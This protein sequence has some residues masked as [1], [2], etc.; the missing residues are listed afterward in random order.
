MS[1]CSVTY[2]EGL[3]E[4]SD[5]SVP[6]WASFI[7]SFS[8]VDCVFVN[9]LVEPILRNIGSITDRSQ[10]TLYTELVRDDLLTVQY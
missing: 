7:F 9:Y 5:W 3:D 6:F 10:V 1:F 2:Q 4:K 8:V